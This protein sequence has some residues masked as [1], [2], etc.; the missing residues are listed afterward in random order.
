MK[1]E[2][3]GSTRYYSIED[4]EGNEYVLTEMYDANSDSTKYEITIDGET[5]DD[6]ITRVKI[7]ATLINHQMNT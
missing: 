1:I 5:L 7:I 6:A 4:D 2:L 3:T